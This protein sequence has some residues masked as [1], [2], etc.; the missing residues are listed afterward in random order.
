MQIPMLQQP[1]DAA[2]VAHMPGPCSLGLSLKGLQ[3]VL[4]AR[5]AVI[6][7]CSPAPW[8]LALAM[9]Y[10]QLAMFAVLKPFH[11]PY[12][13]YDSAQDRIELVGDSCSSAYLAGLAEPV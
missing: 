6:K 9:L 13:G 1:L 5:E 2:E 11:V 10:A 8:P 7:A 3:A 4:P 12:T